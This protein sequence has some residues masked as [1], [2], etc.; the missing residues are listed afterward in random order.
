MGEVI[1]SM[2]S[3]DYGVELDELKA[4]MKDIQRLINQIA[5][6]LTPKAVKVNKAIE[7]DSS[8]QVNE[9]GSV[10]YSGQYRSENSRYKWEPQERQVTQLLEL[11]GDKAAKVLAALGHQQRLDILRM[12]LK[13][14]LTGAELVEHL[15][16]GTT[17]QLYHHI[18]ALS[19]ADL[20]VQEERGGKYS[21]PAH[22]SLP[23]LL[24]LA[25]TFDLLDTSDY[26]ELAETRNNASAYLGESKNP[27]DPHH[28]LLAV[29]ENTI[30]EHKAG[31]CSEVNIFLHHDGSI[32]VSDN[33][34]GIPVQALPGTTKTK[35]QTVLTEIGHYGSDSAFFA[36]GGEKG[37]TIAVVNALSQRLSVEVRRDGKVFRQ[38]YRHGIPQ[39][40]LLT[41]GVTKETGTSITFLPDKEIFGS[42]F[43]HSVVED[44]VSEISSAYPKLAIHFDI[45]KE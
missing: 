6:E 43:N 38:D 26:M 3:R 20:L 2:N 39:T 37:I 1:N 27:F 8:H 36:P 14:P 16:M 30:L 24:L 29:V 31:F 11:D 5:D 45:D 21:L 15:N 41:V 35:V 7:I 22:R 12:V 40:G 9:L 18:K 33:G 25:A 13:Q 44:R 4:Q 32:T 23:L 10:Y 28:L 42:A 34:R 19:G 17:G